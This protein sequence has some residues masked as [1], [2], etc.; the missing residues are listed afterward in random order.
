MRFDHGE[1][2]LYCVR[3]ASEITF[4]LLRPLFQLDE[5]AYNF[6]EFF[7]VFLWVERIAERRRRLRRWRRPVCQSV[8]AGSPELILLRRAV[9]SPRITL[10]V[11]PEP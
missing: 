3:R 10:W 1:V 9:Y 8:Q 4:F 6:D 2:M 5:R 7:R 11:G